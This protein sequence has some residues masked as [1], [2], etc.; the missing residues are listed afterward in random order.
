MHKCDYIDET[1]AALRASPQMRADAVGLLLAEALSYSARFSL[2]FDGR[3]LIA[4]GSADAAALL[5]TLRA[6][7]AIGS[8]EVHEELLDG[9][10]R[11]L[12]HQVLS[13]RR[14]KWVDPPLNYI[15][16]VLLFDAENHLLLR[17][18]DSCEFILFVLPAAGRENLI[19]RYREAGIPEDI[20]K[21]V[22]I[23][24]DRGI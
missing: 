14:E 5:P 12:L 9:D 15:E 4:L 23:D 20:I 21:K 6:L 17:G 2:E 1:H 8:A 7:P 10:R 18:S 3:L 13:Y 19:S 11:K 16:R 24:I 22:D